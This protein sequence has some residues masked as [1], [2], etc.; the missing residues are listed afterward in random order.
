MPL[1]LL[2]SHF[3]ALTHLELSPFFNPGESRQNYCNWRLERPAPPALTY[4]RLDDYDVPMLTQ[5]KA[6]DVLTAVLIDELFANARSRDLNFE[7][8]VPLRRFPAYLRRLRRGI[9]DQRPMVR[10]LVEGFV[11][12][13][14]AREGQ[15]GTPDTQQS[16]DPRSTTPDLSVCHLRVLTSKRVGVIPPILYGEKRPRFV[17]RYDSRHPNRFIHNAH[18]AQST[19]QNGDISSEDEDMNVAFSNVDESN[20]ALMPVTTA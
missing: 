8:D 20:L 18:Q 17:V 5:R 15:E 9:H 14:R 6:N 11:R 12:L 3:H 19:W 10:K 2:L 7:L 4:L 16:Q 1:N 13:V